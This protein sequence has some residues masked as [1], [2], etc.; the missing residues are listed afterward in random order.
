M[1][2]RRAFIKKTTLGATAISLPIIPSLAKTPFENYIPMNEPKISLAQ[3]SLNKAFF[4]GELDAKDFASIAKNSYGIAAIEY[5][6]QFYEDEAEKEKFWLEMAQ[7][8]SDNGV[9]SLIM[10]VDEKEKLGDSNAAKRIKAVED[11]YKWVNAAK[12]LGCHSVR[13]N[14]FG[15]GEPEALK[16]ALVDGLGRLTE[17]AAKENVCVI[18]ENH[19]LHTS[20]AAYMVDIIKAVDNPFLGTLPDFGNWCTSAEWGGTKES[21]NCTSIYDPAKGLTEWL[22]YAKGVS[23]KSYE[24]NEDGYDTVIDYPKL[25]GIVKDAGFDGYIGIEYEGEGLSASEGIVATKA[26]IERTWAALD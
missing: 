23:A 5:V 17:Y 3:W 9:N 25:L 19:G 24:F 16:A 12:L 26:L 6:N 4:S 13:V 11:H 10:M 20:N 22:P 2:T 8:A 7:R 21:Q 14:A 15:D 18:L 1:T